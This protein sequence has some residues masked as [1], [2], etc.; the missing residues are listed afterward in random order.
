MRVTRSG[1]VDHVR[2]RPR[3]DLHLLRPRLPAT[4]SM[5]T[6][7]QIALHTNDQEASYSRGRTGKSAVLAI[8]T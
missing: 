7:V 5:H 4:S 1:A 8:Q 2:E 3:A 6:Q